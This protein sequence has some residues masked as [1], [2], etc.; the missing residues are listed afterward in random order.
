MRKYVVPTLDTVEIKLSECIATVCDGSCT[1]S[2]EAWDPVKG[3]IVWLT[4]LS[5]S[6]V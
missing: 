2:G 3:K 6:G 1:E 4:A 5:T